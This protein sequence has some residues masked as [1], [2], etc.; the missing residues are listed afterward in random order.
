MTLYTAGLDLV[1]SELVTLGPHGPY[2]LT[3]NHGKGSIVEYFHSVNDALTREV[4]LEKL[5]ISARGVPTRKGVA[6]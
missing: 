6:A 2:R 3:V 5:L 4:E 1:R